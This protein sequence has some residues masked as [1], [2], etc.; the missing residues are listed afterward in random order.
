[1]RVTA[2]VARTA[3]ESR[4]LNRE[5]EPKAASSRQAS[6]TDTNKASSSAASATST[7]SA[8]TDPGPAARVAI[9]S[10]ARAALRA[11]GVPSNEIARI[12]LSDK[13]AVAR[14]IQRARMARGQP[15]AAK[16]SASKPESKISSAKSGSEARDEDADELPASTK[17]VS[18]AEGSKPSNEQPPEHVQ[19]VA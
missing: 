8:A 2:S 17:T 5:T 19:A 1:M 16:A 13:N 15:T 7:A 9:S 12:N 14:A 10:K 6:E 4:A 3:S 18:S 11:A